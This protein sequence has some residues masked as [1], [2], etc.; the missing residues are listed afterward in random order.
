MSVFSADT[1]PETARLLL[2]GYRR[3]TAAQ[4]LARVVDLSLASRQMAEARI[5]AQYPRA[6]ER[7][8]RMRIAALTLGRDL[9]KRAYGWDP[10]REG[11]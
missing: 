7:E 3:M 4:K 11:W 2:E 5:R 10:E 6:D 1:R 9:V 8:I